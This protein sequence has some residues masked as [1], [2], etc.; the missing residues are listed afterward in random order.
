VVHGGTFS[1]T[2]LLIKKLKINK[3]TFVL[4]PLHNPANLQGIIVAEDF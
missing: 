1:D 3:R 4:A 2:V